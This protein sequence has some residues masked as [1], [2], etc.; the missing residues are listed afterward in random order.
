[1]SHLVKGAGETSNPGLGKLLGEIE[2]SR[3]RGVEGFSLQD[4][5]TTRRVSH[6][7]KCG[8]EILENV[9]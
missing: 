7:K 2:G 4:V 3:R 9:F 6:S 8:M 5:Q 1:M